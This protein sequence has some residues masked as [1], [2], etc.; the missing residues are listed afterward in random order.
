MPVGL[1][2]TSKRALTR[3]LAAS[4]LK[5]AASRA[6]ATHSEPWPNA[7]AVGVPDWM[8]VV[9]RGE[10]HRL[11]VRHRPEFRHPGARRGRARCRRSRRSRLRRRALRRP[12]SGVDRWPR[13][14]ACSM[15]ICD[16][17]PSATLATQ[18]ERSSAA[19]RLRP[20]ADGHVRDDPTA[21]GVDHGDGL[22]AAVSVSSPEP[23]PRDGGDR[24]AESEEPYPLPPTP[25][26]GPPSPPSRSCR[27][28]GCVECRVLSENRGLELH[29][30]ATRL[31]AEFLLHRA[32]G[33]G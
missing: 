22:G 12:M 26:R 5:T 29:Q 21:L 1:L 14:A 13:R 4:I 31:H 16:T 27:S 7:A 6:L 10:S 17:L 25:R 11:R 32:P 20:G 8:P 30:L 23:V 9:Q 28:P 15:S 2:P 33:A 19:T 24:R 3:L 18:T